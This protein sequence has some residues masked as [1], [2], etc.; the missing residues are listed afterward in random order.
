LGDTSIDIAGISSEIHLIADQVERHHKRCE[1][2]YRGTTAKLHNEEP[3]VHQ[4]ARDRYGGALA[5]MATSGSGL[6][7]PFYPKNASES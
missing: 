7:P 4:R 6:F 1:T 2:P 5:L 3:I